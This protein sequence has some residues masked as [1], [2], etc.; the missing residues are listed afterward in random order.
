MPRACP[1]DAAGLERLAEQYGTPLQ[2]YDEEQIRQN[3]KSLISAFKTH[4]S[5]T[6]RQFFAVKALPNPAILSVLLSEGCGLDCSSAAELHIAQT[7]GVPG[8]RILLTSNFTSYALLRSAVEA[9]AIVNLDDASLLEPLARACRELSPGAD[10]SRPLSQLPCISFRLNPGLGT[11]DSE[12]SSNVLGGPNA[13]FGI[14][15]DQ[16]VSAY[17]QARCLGATRFGIHCMTGSCVRNTAYWEELCARLVKVAGIVRRRLP[18]LTFDFINIG[19]GLGIPYRPDQKPIDLIHTAGAIGRAIRSACARIG[20]ASVPSVWMENGRFV[21]GPFGWLVTRCRAVKRG[22]GRTYYGLDAN[23]AH[24]MR[25]GM[26][27]AY[28]HITIPSRESSAK[29]ALASVVGT[30]C[31]NNDWFCRDRSLPQ[32][33]KRCDLFVIH[34]TGAHSHS[35]G[36]QYNGTLRA[37]ELLLRSDGRV[38]LIRQRET[39]KDLFGNT[40]MPLDLKRN[41]KIR[42]HKRCSGAPRQCSRRLDDEACLRSA[43]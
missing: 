41:Q 25:P 33:V 22:F 39:I 16:I 10:P 1:L 3:V 42:Q 15:P 17:E 27:G 11:T 24:L 31:E 30:L 29:R 19:G 35:M 18:G 8:H 12:T 37:P 32:G 14:S 2:L 40:R 4:T 36:F 28:H 7:L 23:M 21:T 20:W 13:K 26:Y 34:D 5:P 9:K 6:F 43:L 38:D